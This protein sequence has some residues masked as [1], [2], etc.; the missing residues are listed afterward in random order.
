MFIEPPLSLTKLPNIVRRAR[1]IGVKVEDLE[2]GTVSPM[3]SMRPD[4]NEGS[5]LS[6]PSQHQL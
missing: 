4:N 5:R 3:M 6:M 2:G 1:T